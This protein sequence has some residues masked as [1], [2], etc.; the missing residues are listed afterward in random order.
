[1]VPEFTYGKTILPVRQ[2]LHGFFTLTK[3]NARQNYAS[4]RGKT[5]G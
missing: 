5:M 4:S 2:C 1:M 3:S